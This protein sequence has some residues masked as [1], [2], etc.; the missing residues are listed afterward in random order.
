MAGACGGEFYPLDISGVS[1][2]NSLASVVSLYSI[3]S[4]MAPMV[5]CVFW[6]S[7]FPAVQNLIQPVETFNSP[8]HQL[9]P[10][11]HGNP[12][13]EKVMTVRIGNSAGIVPSQSPSGDER[14]GDHQFCIILSTK[15]IAILVVVIEW[16]LAEAFQKKVS[17]LAFE[18]SCKRLCRETTL[19]PVE[20]RE[21]SN[22]H[23]E[24][25]PG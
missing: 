22:W 16:K 13:R 18:P 4:P 5:N 3:S 25:Q 11:I 12:A 6:F 7:V 14:A 17:T 23:C 10:W 15:V 9:F 21:I 1:S 20:L 24:K 8:E 2:M 19:K